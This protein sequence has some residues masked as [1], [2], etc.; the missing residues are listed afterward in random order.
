MYA[1]HLSNF[2]R[3]HI[4][5]I[6]KTI[7][8]WP[9][10]LNSLNSLNFHHFFYLLSYATFIISCFIG[11][12]LSLSASLILYLIFTLSRVCGLSS[13]LSLSLSRYLSI[14]ISLFRLLSGITGGRDRSD[15]H[16][17]C[18]PDQSKTQK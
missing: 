11:Q 10:P 8:I 15:P 4:S 17:H 5:W 7:Y 14:S 3:N 13:S 2:R 6:I 16:T 18:G 9:S 12:V 1:S